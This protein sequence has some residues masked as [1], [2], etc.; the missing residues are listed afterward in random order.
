MPPVVS[1]IAALSIDGFV[2]RGRGV[3][4]DLPVDRDHFR[5]CAAGKWLLLGRTTYEEMIGW[6]RD[7]HPLVLSRDPGFRPVVGRR[8]ASVAEA[9]ELAAAAGQEELVVCG[10]AQVYAAALPVADRL[11]LTRVDQRLGGGLAFPAF[12]EAEWPVR[13]RRRHATDALHL[14]AFEIRIHERVRAGS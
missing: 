10:G 6:F 7:H 14:Q 3:P 1:L 13:A 8:V 5:A 4:W 11:I 2:S 9:R 12:D